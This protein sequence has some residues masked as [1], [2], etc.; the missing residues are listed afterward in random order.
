MK[1]KSTI[2][3]LCVAALPL[4]AQLSN[5]DVRNRLELIHSGKGDQVRN[6][7]PA[8]QRQYPNDAGVKYLDAYLTESGDNAVRKYQAIVDLHP[9]SEWADD[10]LYKV[11]QYYYA[12]ALYKT[13]DAKMKQL[14][15]QYPNSIY[16]NSTTNPEEKTNIQMTNKSESKNEQ[17]SAEAKTEIGRTPAAQP[18]FGRFAVQVGV[19]SQEATAQQQAQQYSQTIG[20]LATVFSKQSGDRTL[21]A[22]AFEGFENEQAARTFGVELK[23]KFNLDWF[24]VKR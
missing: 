11:Y 4:M 6:E 9:I 21:F 22:V 23:S 17:R 5:E 15:Q 13:A 2:M 3:L 1:K 16:A 24:L 18:A 14:N 12:V 20:R 8:L 10:A 19:Y 7:V